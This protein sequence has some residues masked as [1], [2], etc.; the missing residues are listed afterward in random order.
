MQATIPLQSFNLDAKRTVASAATAT[1]TTPK[2]QKTQIAYLRT[3]SAPTP[4]ALPQLVQTESQKLTNARNSLAT[5]SWT[6]VKDQLEKL[7]NFK[8]NSEESTHEPTTMLTTCASSTAG[9]TILKIEETAAAAA[10]AAA[11]AHSTDAVNNTSSFIKNMRHTHL[12]SKQN[13]HQH[14]L[15]S[16]DAALDADNHISINNAASMATFMPKRERINHAK[17]ATSP[18]NSLSPTPSTNGSN[19]LLTPTSKVSS[20]WTDATKKGSTST[21]WTS[22]ESILRSVG[23]ADE[24][25]K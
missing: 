4:Y 5:P 15:A 20:T 6:A 25:N 21:I 11:S 9:N 17:T 14:A 23:A 3:L 22:E 12:T 2:Q 18:K 13:S 7:T 1:S 10:A 16:M 24:D 19:N 8:L